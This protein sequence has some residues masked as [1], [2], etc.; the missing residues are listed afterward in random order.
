[1]DGHRRIANH[2]SVRCEDENCVEIEP[3]VLNHPKMA[4]DHMLNP[5]G[6]PSTGIIN[7]QLI[8]KTFSH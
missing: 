1:M 2:M 3:K 6:W 7:N 8:I 5:E 4:T